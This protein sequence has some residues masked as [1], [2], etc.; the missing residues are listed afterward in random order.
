MT[1][2]DELDGAAAEPQTSEMVEFLKALAGEDEL[3]VI[4]RAHIHIENQVERFLAAVLPAPHELGSLNY[5]TKVRIALACGLRP[6]L[7]P[8]LKSLGA[9]RNKFAHEPGKV[10]SAG[11]ADAILASLGSR[12]KAALA[13]GFTQLTADHPMK[14]AEAAA[15]QRVSFYLATLWASMISER[16]RVL[17]IGRTQHRLG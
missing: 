11:D 6:D 9:L 14:A 2:D 5:A 1:P 17:A 12:E 3:G 7:K 4:V 13:K 10:L 15:K 16:M 8:A